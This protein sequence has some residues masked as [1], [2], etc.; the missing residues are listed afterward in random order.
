MIVIAH[1]NVAM[2]HCQHGTV[3]GRYSDDM[4]L[5]VAAVCS[6]AGL[7]SFEGV[8]STEGEERSFELEMTPGW[9]WS[10]RGWG[11]VDWY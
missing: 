11:K 3:G 5:W 8:D 9:M 7:G 6:G 10:G 2:G 4:F 1:G